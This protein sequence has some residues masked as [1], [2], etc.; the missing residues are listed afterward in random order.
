MQNEGSMWYTRRIV[1]SQPGALFISVKSQNTM[2]L[3]STVIRYS[4]N[5]R[6]NVDPQ[7]GLFVNSSDNSRER[8]LSSPRSFLVCLESV[9]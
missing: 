5:C 7:A 3:S 6:L 2:T 1:Q 4:L 9:R 8:G